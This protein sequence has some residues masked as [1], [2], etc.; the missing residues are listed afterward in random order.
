[1]IEPGQKLAIGSDHAG[2]DMK[3]D[4]K[5]MLIEMGYEVEDMGTHDKSSCDYPDFAAA[6]AHAVADKRVAA[7]V[8][9]CSTGIGISIAANKVHGIR[10]ALVHHAYE[11]EMT[12]R[13]NDANIICFGAN[14]T[15]PAIAREAVKTFLKTDFEGG[16]HQRRIDKMMAL[17]K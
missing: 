7:G 15:G 1:M 10:A 8:L 12:R 14:I 2:F 3:E 11:A 9:V 5:K 13:H 17:E 4:L 16:R 6:V